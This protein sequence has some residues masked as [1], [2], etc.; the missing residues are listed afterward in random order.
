MNQKGQTLIELL[1][2]LSI[3][4]IVITTVA[5]SLTTSLNNAQASRTSTLATKYAQEGVE[6]VR[7]LRDASYTTFRT[8]N[9]LYCLGKDQQSLGT[10]QSSCTTANYD[11]F[12]RSVR[13]EQNVGCG[14]NT[15]RVTV[16]VS[17]KDGKCPTNSYCH[18]AQHV[19]CLST[20]NRV[21]A[22]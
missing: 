6:H 11:Q 13:I 5:V 18:T 16:L 3:L 1:V 8:Y 19:S 17:W 21:T 7:S 4:V 2:A 12:I 9:G 14:T 20:V 15:A 22:P 10:V